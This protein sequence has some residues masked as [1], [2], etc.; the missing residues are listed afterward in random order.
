MNRNLMLK[1]LACLS[2]AFTLSACSVNPVSGTPDLVFM[3]ESAEI[4]KGKEMH[5]QILKSM[6]IYQDE[7]LSKYINDIGQK[8]AAKSHRPDITYH[9]TIIDAPD[10]N[11][12]ALPGGYI[13]INRGI[14]AYLESEAQLAA[15]L[16]HEIAHV[17][18][19]HVVRQ[20]A[21]RKGASALSVAT[22]ITTGSA[23][24]GDVANMWGEA[25]VSGYGR[26]MELEA[27]GLGAEYLYNSGYAPEAMIDTIGVLKDQEKFARYRTKEEGKKAKSYHGVFSTH[28]RNDTRLKEIIAKAGTLPED[29][30][31]HQNQ[32]TFREKTQGMVFGVNYQAQ[33]A[34]KEE[35]KQRYFHNKLGFSVLFPPEW[36]V[37]NTR[38]AIVSEAQDK[39]A[40]MSLYVARRPKDQSPEQYL[41]S[42]TGGQLVTKQEGFKQFNQL[43]YTGLMEAKEQETPQRVAVIYQGGKAFYLKGEV[44]NSQEGTE[45]DELFMGAIRSFRPESSARSNRKS[46]TIH[47]VKANDKTT[48]EALA[49]HI[50]LGAY[51]VQYLRLING[52][53][54]RGEPEPGQWIKI[55][56]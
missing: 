34:Q 20:D 17:T 37:R 8:L 40:M 24:V 18:A 44:V 28:P 42:V 45:Y 54:P 41:R 12:F 31:N 7:A 6:P 26:D 46:K 2:L 14:L 51:T 16:A 27:D 55:V 9:F 25:A 52:M 36:Q 53:Y 4:K 39:S 48:F 49:K 33:L 43:V 13:Y 29:K 23:T 22:T 35:D 1:F 10:I 56:K 15:I 50:N 3:S 38:N 47:Y 30:T 5:E 21:A 19:R 32:E 11:A